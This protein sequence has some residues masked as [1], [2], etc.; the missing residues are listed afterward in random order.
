MSAIKEAFVKKFGEEQTVAIEKAAEEHRNMSNG[1]N[2]GD[3]F[4]W[5]LLIAIGY[6]C[7]EIDSHREYHGITIPFNEFKSWVKEHGNL[8]NY[9]GDM[10]YLALFA[11]IYDEYVKVEDASLEA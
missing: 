5:A 9:V 10:D 8:T 3:L 1:T 6:Q 4:Q 2:R 7:A 11:G